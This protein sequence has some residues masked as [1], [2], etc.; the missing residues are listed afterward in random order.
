M[1]EGARVSSDARRHCEGEGVRVSGGEPW[2]APAHPDARGGLS[3]RG[4]GTGGSARAP[5]PPRPS[6]GGGRAAPR[7]CRGR[8]PPPPR[9][10]IRMRVHDRYRQAQSRSAK[11]RSKRKAL[12]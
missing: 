8:A 6:C 7:C 10:G 12:Q 3:R 1:S 2:P 11:Q 4:R 9:Y 5:R